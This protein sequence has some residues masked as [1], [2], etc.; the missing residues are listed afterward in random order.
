V[1]GNFDFFPKEKTG[2]RSKTHRK[3]A[4]VLKNFLSNFYIF[5]R[6]YIATYD[7]LGLL[8]SKKSKLSFSRR[9]AVEKIFF[10]QQYDREVGR[11]KSK[12]L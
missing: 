1:L 8:D 12:K 11:K 5:L 2:C 9:S 10:G 4:N 7:Y 3:N 6:K